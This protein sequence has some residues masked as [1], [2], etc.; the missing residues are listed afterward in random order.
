VPSLALAGFRESYLSEIVLC[1]A[2]VYTD[3]A[4]LHRTNSPA[5][6]LQL[7]VT[8]SNKFLQQVWLYPATMQQDHR[9][10]LP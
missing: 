3:F 8:P 4:G 9:I 2:L 5:T 7:P 1:S 10:T 6:R